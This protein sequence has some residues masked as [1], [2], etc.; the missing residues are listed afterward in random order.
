MASEICFVA[1]DCC[2]C[3]F[4]PAALFGFTVL[5][6][7]DCRG[8]IGTAEL[9]TMGTVAPC[10]NGG[11]GFVLVTVVADGKRRS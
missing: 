8:R 7:D 3:V 4:T 11:R 10:G 1:L 6:V 5:V 9:F 2:C